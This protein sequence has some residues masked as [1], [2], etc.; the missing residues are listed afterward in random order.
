MRKAL[1]VS[2]CVFLVPLFT[3]AQYYSFKENSNPQWAE[4]TELLAQAARL[5]SDL[6]QWTQHN[7]QR[8]EAPEKYSRPYH[9][10]AWVD[11]PRTPDCFDVR[12]LI[13][14]RDSQTR[15]QMSDV[16]PCKVFSGSWKDPY[17]GA[18]WKLAR[19]IEIDHVVAL[20]NAYSSGAWAWDYQHRCLFA[21]FTGFD[22]HLLSSSSTENKQKSDR[23][24]EGWMP[25]REDYSCQHLHNWLAIKYIWNLTM[26]VVE[27][28][29][30]A[31][32]VEIH[33]CNLKAFQF[34][35]AELNRIRRVAQANLSI[36][37]Q[38]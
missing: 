5:T 13:L 33:Q 20:K 23:G 10:G 30:I 28:E 22:K 27:A 7:S 1:L 26:T 9:F 4:P 37:R 24:P 29:A 31:E 14:M 19:E 2:V 17:G 25:S 6:L 32:L 15:V 16:S 35:K 11:D 3:S 12:A 21:N 34:S 38:H 8:P 18:T 36:C